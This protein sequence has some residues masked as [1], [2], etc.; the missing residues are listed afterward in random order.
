MAPGPQAWPGRKIYPD[1]AHG[2][3]IGA[4]RG[5]LPR[6][7]RIL[8]LS[9]HPDDDVLG[10][11]G[12]L[13]RLAARQNRVLVLYPTDGAGGVTDAFARAWLA[14]RGRRPT[15]A[16]IGGAKQAIRRGEARRSLAV[17]GRIRHRFLVLPFYR[18]P[19]REVG[20]DDVRTLAAA[21]ARERPD[22]AFGTGEL[23]DPR[24]T[25]AR[26]M[27]AFFAAIA[28][29]SRRL[30]RPIP[31]WLYRGA[32]ESWRPAQ[33]DGTVFLSPGEARRKR[34]AFLAHRSQ[35][36][37]PV[38]GSDPR[39]F[40]KRVESRNRSLARSLARR[41]LPAGAACEGFRRVRSL[42]RALAWALRRAKARRPPA[43]G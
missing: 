3:N 37:P 1:T 10:M 40:W 41:G 8:V 5:F 9:P 18:R 31:V 33:V 39:P 26:A 22:L 23:S 35:D 29:A 17:L 13:R 20:A 14:R 34:A 12:T 30:G 4:V 11:G 28:R 2:V 19:G 7:Q 16:A 27:A 25:H 24:G 6:G 36:P 15:A 32:W 43:L 42:P 38:G 21:I